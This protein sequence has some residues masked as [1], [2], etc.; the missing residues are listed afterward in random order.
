L[1]TAIHDRKI[2]TINQNQVYQLRKNMEKQNR[3]KLALF[4]VVLVLAS[5][6]TSKVFVT[7]AEI[8][9]DCFK[10]EHKLNTPCKSND[11]CFTCMYCARCVEK[12]CICFE[13]KTV[14]FVRRLAM[15]SI[16]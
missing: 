15:H 10:H 16:S 1:Q 5:G 7:A 2:N 9:I 11:D 6:V 12:V 3:Y 4:V 13:E 8:G 14:K